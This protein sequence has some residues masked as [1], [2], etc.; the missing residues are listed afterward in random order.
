M[1]AAQKVTANLPRD[2]LERAQRVT[3]K[4]V[5]ATL[6]EALE[7]LERESKRTALRKL[8]G[9]IRFGLDLEASRK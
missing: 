5:T 6:V 9:K 1:S 4:G 8:R 2:L 7:A 3:S